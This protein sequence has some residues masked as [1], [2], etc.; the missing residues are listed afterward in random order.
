MVAGDLMISDRSMR[1]DRVGQSQSRSHHQVSTLFTMQ[2][3]KIA[4]FS[5]SVGVIGAAAQNVTHGAVAMEIA[6]C[7]Q[8]IRKVGTNQKYDIVKEVKR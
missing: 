5:L 3:A 8:I 6:E 4:S 7:S 2:L 1:L